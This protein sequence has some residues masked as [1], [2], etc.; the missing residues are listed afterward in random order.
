MIDDDGIAVREPTEGELAFD[1]VYTSS[2]YAVSMGSNKATRLFRYFF[3]SI[4]LSKHDND[5]KKTTATA[6]PESR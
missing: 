4:G 5:E 6:E 3:P 2:L 1:S